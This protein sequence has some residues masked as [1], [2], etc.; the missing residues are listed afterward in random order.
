MIIIP[1]ISSKAIGSGLSLS[2]SV[3][4]FHVL[5][6]S[7][8][9]NYNCTFTLIFLHLL[10]IIHS[11]SS[12]LAHS[13]SLSLFLKLIFKS[14]AKSIPIR[15]LRVTSVCRNSERIAQIDSH[16]VL[17]HALRERYCPRL[18]MRLKIIQSS[19]QRAFHKSCS[20]TYLC[21]PARAE[22]GM[23]PWFEL[24]K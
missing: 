7:L 2:L 15:S 11:L 21:S 3:Y 16:Q 1:K 18:Q 24:S 13:I 23:H 20:T 12:F 4:S 22:H 8:S 5:Y 6:H 19:F 17:S 10:F 14:V 9:S